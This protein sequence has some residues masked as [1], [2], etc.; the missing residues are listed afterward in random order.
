VTSARLAA[1]CVELLGAIEGPV[2]LGGAGALATVLAARVRAAR[3]GEPAAAAVCVF[4]D[5]GVDPVARRT[6]LAALA[7]RLPEDA[8]LVAVDH[9]QPRVWWRRALGALVLVAR[10]HAPAR[11]RHP[12]AREV[13]AAG[14]AVERLCLADGERIQLVVGR[15]RAGPRESRS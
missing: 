13:Q 7:A 10:G 4:L 6:R 15:R 2:D 11:A 12:V 1:R 8:P 9:N 14:F 5:E 3:D